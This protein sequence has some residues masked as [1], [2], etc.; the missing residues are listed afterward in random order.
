ML[1]GTMI[2]TSKS[3]RPARSHRPLSVRAAAVV[4]SAIAAVVAPPPAMSETDTIVLTF[5]GDV[6]YS[7]NHTPVSPEGISKRGFQRWRDTTD[8]IAS[9]IDGDLNFMN[10]ETVVTDRNDLP[11]DLKGQS[12]PFNF[13]T[14]PEGIAHLLLTGFNVFSLANNHSMDYGLPGLKETLHHVGELYGSGLKAAAGLGM[15]R[16]E[17]S[18]PHI[19]DVKGAKVGFAAIGIVTNNLA[20]HRAGE[21]QPGQIAYRFDDDYALIRKRLREAK[22]DIRILSIHYGTEG[23]VRTDARQ[24][25]E[26]RAEAA[27]KDGIDIIVGHHAHVVRGVEIVDKSLILY[28][29]GNFLH[30]GTADITGKGVCRDY[31]LMARVYMHRGRDGRFAI[32][33]VQAIPVTDTHYRPRRLTGTEGAKRIFGLNYLATTLDSSD[34][35]KGLRFTPQDD[36]T[37]LYC[38]PDGQR[39]NGTLGRLCAGY[40]PAPPLPSNY[41]KQI[42]ESCSR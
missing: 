42:A 30:H 38:S 23:Q 22:A 21:N 40:K 3:S 34:G 24:I 14:H 35:A 26:W 33:A 5:V 13:R 11:R 29:L 20:H 19:I 27:R 37:G 1:T 6:G 18:R 15:N 7:G 2:H 32:A 31:G 9:E 16:E 25:Q 39:A 28:G 41:E 12:G 8:R 10:V 4:L 36:G 17:A